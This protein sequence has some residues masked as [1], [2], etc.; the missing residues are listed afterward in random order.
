MKIRNANIKD[1]DAVTAIESA[2][3]PIEQAAK[4]EDFEKRLKIYPNHFWVMEIDDKIVSLINGLTTDEYNLTDRLMENP[5]LHNEKGKWL[6]IFGVATDPLYRKRGYA[7]AI[8]NRVIEEAK[9][10]GRS[11]IVL[12]CKD[13]LIPF[14]EQFG[15]VREGISEST[16]GGVTWN[17]MRLLLTDV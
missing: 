8:M 9:N 11:G 3:F 1:V 2:S 14:Y 13:R 5:Q 4:K 10:E 16:H 6:M 17:S 15:F 12:T 7:K